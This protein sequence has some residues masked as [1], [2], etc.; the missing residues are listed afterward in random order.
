MCK[1]PHNCHICN[2]YSCS[3]VGDSDYG[4]TYDT[5]C[6]CQLDK[7]YDEDNDSL[8]ENF[9]YNS[10]KEC[11]NPE[12]WL[13]LE[14]DEELKKMYTDEVPLS[15]NL[16]ETNVYKKFEEKYLKK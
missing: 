6:T 3:E 11:C 4:A 5:K 14:L 2:N 10:I 12:F 9:D 1:I 8:L 7:D 13:V 15:D 16:Y